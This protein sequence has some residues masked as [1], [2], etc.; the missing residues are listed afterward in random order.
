MAGILEAATE[1]RRVAIVQSCERPDA[2]GAA[3]AAEL[4]R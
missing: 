3:E 1:Q 4:L 2:L